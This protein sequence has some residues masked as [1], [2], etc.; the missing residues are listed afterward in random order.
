MIRSREEFEERNKLL[1]ST[2]GPTFDISQIKMLEND[3]DENNIKCDVCQWE[4]DC[5][6]DE[7]VIC[8]M[9]IAATHQTCYGSEIYDRLP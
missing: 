6:G 9:C 1:N 2:N 7:I 8:E 5:E 3:D 4:D